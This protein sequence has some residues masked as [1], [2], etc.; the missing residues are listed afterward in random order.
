M[1]D[2]KK[3][4]AAEKANFLEIANLNKPDLD[5]PITKLS[6]ITIEDYMMTAFGGGDYKKGQK[7]TENPNSGMLS[8]LDEYASKLVYSGDDVNAMID[9]IRGSSVEEF[10]THHLTP[11]SEYINEKGYSGYE[12]KFKQLRMVGSRY[13]ISH[14]VVPIQILKDLEGGAKVTKNPKSTPFLEPQSAKFP[15]KMMTVENLDLALRKIESEINLAEQKIETRIDPET[16]KKLSIGETDKLRTRVDMLHAGRAGL[17]YKLHTG[18]RGGEAFSLYTFDHEA[19]EAYDAKTKKLEKITNPARAINNTQFS[20]FQKKID[21]NTTKY[22]IDVP[23]TIT[24]VPGVDF[25]VELDPRIGA[26]LDAQAERVQKMILNGKTSRSI[27]GFGKYKNGVLVEVVDAFDYTKMTSKKTKGVT[28]KTVDVPTAFNQDLK[29]FL[30]GEK[31]VLAISGISWNEN[32]EIDDPNTGQT[33]K[34]ASQSF[35]NDH[36]IRGTLITYANTH[37]SRIKDIIN[38]ANPDNPVDEGQVIRFIDYSTGRDALND[39]NKKHYQR[40]PPLV[41]MERWVDY[42]KALNTLMLEDSEELQKLTT[43]SLAA[44]GYNPDKTGKTNTIQK[45]V[46]YKDAAV[47]TTSVGDQVDKTNEIK[48]VITED[49]RDDL[50]YKNRK[51]YE[52]ILSTEG[53]GKAKEFYDKIFSNRGTKLSFAGVGAIQDQMSEITSDFKA[54]KTLSAVGKS[55]P[56]VGPVVGTALGVYYYSKP[57]SAYGITGNETEEELRKARSTRA[58]SE[59]ASG[60]NPIPE[61]AAL[62]IAN[63]LPGEQNLN[64]MSAAEAIAPTRAEVEA[65]KNSGSLIFG[66]SKKN[67]V[68]ENQQQEEVIEPQTNG[69]D[70]YSQMQNLMRSRLLDTNPKTL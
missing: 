42:S 59:I 12:G 64:I 17:I 7:V 24:K 56:F 52:R 2:N 34:G 1:A 54:G 63:V 60:F 36:D 26:I 45:K 65:R 20:T 55:L 3:I 40:K 57:L 28:R 50:T 25:S 37:K 8:H 47:E 14:N 62:N 18:L 67:V 70:I 9:E 23:Q 16:G 46:T 38:A 10:F 61:P 41:P 4:I 32:I 39:I 51:E 58:I 35:F 30:F 13:N 6:D 11:F 29:K 15:N 68:D 53:E 48:P 49:I 21:G 43:K 19:D 33:I 66:D 27:F 22:L 5:Q 44:I 31:G 69:N